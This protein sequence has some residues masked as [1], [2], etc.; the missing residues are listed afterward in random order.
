MKRSD[1]GVGEK[2]SSRTDEKSFVSFGSDGSA[3]P[4]VDGSFGVCMTTGRCGE[5][6]MDDFTQ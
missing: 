6:Q 3:V 2:R 1:F 4:S 5:A